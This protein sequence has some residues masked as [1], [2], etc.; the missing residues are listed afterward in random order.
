MASVVL[1]NNNDNPP[2]MIPSGSYISQ[3]KRSASLILPIHTWL[4][5]FS[6][7]SASKLS[8]EC[9]PKFKPSRN[10]T[11]KI[12][13]G[14]SSTSLSTR[15]LHSGHL[16]SFLLST[17]SLKHLLQNVC[18]H[19]RTLQPWSS[20]LRQTGHSKSSFNCIASMILIDQQT[21]VD[22]AGFLRKIFTYQV[23]NSLRRNYSLSH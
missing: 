11:R 1:R 6:V 17:I 14:K 10:R 12:F 21:H 22:H 13:A 19:G 3:Q 16:N 15:I 2:L 9:L 7:V 23:W 5:D 18:W 8:E 4:Q 20:C